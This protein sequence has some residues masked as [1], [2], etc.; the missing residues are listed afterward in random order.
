MDECAV[1]Y[2][3]SFEPNQLRSP[4]HQRHHRQND[5]MI[6]YGVRDAC[7]LK[8]NSQ[9][10]YSRC[11]KQPEQSLTRFKGSITVHLRCIAAKQAE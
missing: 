3:I 5:S 11:N 10:I 6:Y 4:S 2:I 8:P 1:T 7:H 9:S